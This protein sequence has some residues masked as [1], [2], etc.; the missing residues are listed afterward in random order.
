MNIYVPLVD[1]YETSVWVELSDL[2]DHHL[3]LWYGQA[4]VKS[5]NMKLIMV[6]HKHTCICT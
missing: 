3:L 6:N 1:S 2:L 5:T 4:S